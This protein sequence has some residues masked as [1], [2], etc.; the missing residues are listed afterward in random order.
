MLPR[1]VILGII[2]I[3]VGCA[4]V[5]WGGPGTTG[6]PGGYEPFIRFAGIALV[7]IGLILV[8][9]GALGGVDLHDGHRDFVVGGPTVVLT[10]LAEWRRRMRAR[11]ATII[12]PR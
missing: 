4:L 5:Y 9:V 7:V 12:S 10:R 2:L 8:V 3:L 1:M 11:R 6:H